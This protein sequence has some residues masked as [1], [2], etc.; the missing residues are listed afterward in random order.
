MSLRASEAEIEALVQG[1]RRLLGRGEG[2][3]ETLPR[4]ERSR[5]LGAA[6]GARCRAREREGGGLEGGLDGGDE[7][8]GGPEAE[9]SRSLGRLGAERVRAALVRA[10]CG[11]DG[12]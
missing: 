10:D 5:V 11:T 8:C 7:G 6:V 2:R 3:W 12:G 9:E 4:R 1:A